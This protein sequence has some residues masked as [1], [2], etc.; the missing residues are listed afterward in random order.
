LQPAIR[1]RVA[2]LSALTRSAWR[3]QNAAEPIDLGAVVF[4]RPAAPARPGAA[5]PKQVGGQLDLPPSGKAG[6]RPRP[7]SPGS[8]K[9]SARRAANP[10]MTM[11]A[12]PPDLAALGQAVRATRHRRCPEPLGAAPSCMICMSR[13]LDRMEAP[14]NDRQHAAEPEPRQPPTI[15]QS[16][17]METLVV[18]ASARMSSVVST[19]ARTSALGPAA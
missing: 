6:L 4:T 11:P 17:A 13:S 19:A 16:T 1:A 5:D 2:V 18:S 8:G 12:M 10:G 15:L 14:A 3:T 7:E 9:E